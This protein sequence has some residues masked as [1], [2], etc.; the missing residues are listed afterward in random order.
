[1]SNLTM[2]EKLVLVPLLRI[3]D[4]VYR[5]TNGR[6]GQHIPMLPPNLL[7]HRTGAKTGQP[8]ST[9]LTC[10]NDGDSYLIVAT[11]TWETK[12]NPTSTAIGST[13][14]GIKWSAPRRRFRRRRFAA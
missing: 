8:R 12:S 13:G 9:T 6:M 11:L 4:T 2:M 14:P 3:H 7:L 5:N 1:M 10:A